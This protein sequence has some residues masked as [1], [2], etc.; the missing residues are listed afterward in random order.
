MLFIH[1]YTNNVQLSLV[2]F[3]QSHQYEFYSL[4]ADFS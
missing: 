1:R 2:Y 3:V 4:L